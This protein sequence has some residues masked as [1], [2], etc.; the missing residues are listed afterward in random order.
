M[1]FK[2]VKHFGLVDTLE[3]EEKGMALLTHIFMATTFMLD[4]K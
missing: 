2:R 3:G 1:H 4:L